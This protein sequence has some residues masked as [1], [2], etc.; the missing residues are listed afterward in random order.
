[1]EAEVIYKAK[2]GKKF[3][4]PMECEKYERKLGIKPGTVGFAKETFRNIGMDM[5][6]NGQL[7]VL[8]EK[9]A[10][11]HHLITLNI[12]D[13]IEDYVNVNNIAQDKR[14][15]KAQ[16]KVVLKYLEQYNDDDECVYML[17]FC[18][19]MDFKGTLGTM[20]Q[21]NEDFWKKANKYDEDLQN[22]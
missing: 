3:D 19:N 1:M 20:M 18:R 12:D 14:W 4:D 11:W 10:V 5:Y 7:A 2:D 15:M 17:T 21:N 9:K 6:L 13:Y 22:K 16:V 8:H